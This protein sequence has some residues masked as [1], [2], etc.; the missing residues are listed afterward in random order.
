MK[1]TKC[2]VEK[3]KGQFK[4]AMKDGLEPAVCN[5]CSY[6]KPK[7]E[8]K[9]RMDID[10]GDGGSHWLECLCGCGKFFD[11]TPNVRFYPGHKKDDDVVEYEL[12][13]FGDVQ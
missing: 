4:K 9:D 13:K 12:P 8:Y 11:T 3:V 10:R 2:G 6:E 5:Y 1:C 7:I